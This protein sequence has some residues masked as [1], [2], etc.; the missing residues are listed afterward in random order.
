MQAACCHM[1]ESSYAMAQEIVMACMPVGQQRS[2]MNFYAKFER[3][4]QRMRA[5][6]RKKRIKRIVHEGKCA[7]QVR[8]PDALHRLATN[9][10]YDLDLFND[11]RIH[12]YYYVMGIYE[13]YLKRQ[14]SY[15]ATFWYRFGSYAHTIGHTVIT[16]LGMYVP[17]RLS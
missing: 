10:S 9:M 13:E 11:T 17:T 6:T 15:K 16:W 14:S 4:M 8:F 2:F 12:S 5:G 3:R 7:S 1:Q